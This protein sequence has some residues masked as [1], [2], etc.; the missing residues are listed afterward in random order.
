MSW[1]YGSTTNQIQGNLY[2]WATSSSDLSLVF[3]SHTKTAVPFHSWHNCAAK[4]LV[5]DE[6]LKQRC[7]EPH[8]SVYT[9]LLDYSLKESQWLDLD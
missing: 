9:T 4:A 5:G 7:A 3:L 2:Q 6:E 1:P 8:Y